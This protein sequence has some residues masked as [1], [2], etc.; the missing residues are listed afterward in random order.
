MPVAKLFAPHCVGVAANAVAVE[1]LPVMFAS[2]VATV[3]VTPLT[4]TLK[5]LAVESYAIKPDAVGAA[6]PLTG[7]FS[8]EVKVLAPLKLLAP[9]SRG[10]LLES[11]AS[12]RVPLDTL[13]AFKLV[14]P[15]PLPV[16]E[17]LALLN[18]SAFPYVPAVRPLA[19]TFVSPAPLPVNELLALLNVSAPV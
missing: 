17:L 19:V 6:P 1:A 10:T 14:S 18:V 16:K 4:P 12:A 5:R 13:V 7:T 2:V 15:A 3:L 8:E 11:R 9:F